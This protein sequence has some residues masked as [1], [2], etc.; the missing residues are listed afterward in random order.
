L[1]WDLPAYPESYA[2]RLVTI[3]ALAGHLSA[4][5]GRA[6]TGQEVARVLAM[7]IAKLRRLRG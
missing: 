1:L 5:L 2:A 3:A 4:K 7:S 6:P